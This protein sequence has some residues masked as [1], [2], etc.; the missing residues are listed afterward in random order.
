MQDAS[1]HR[2]QS[3]LDSY[4]R[5][6]KLSGVVAAVG[7]GTA[8]P[9]F[10]YAGRLSDDPGAS[11]VGPDSLWRI[12]SMTKPI[13]AMAAMLLVQDSKL[14]LDEPISDFIPA[15]KNV[16]VMI[17][18]ETSLDSRP[19]HHPIT[20]RELL[21]H[22]SGLGYQVIGTGPL[23]KEYA[24]LHLLGGRVAGPANDLQPNSL[25]AFAD[26]V[27][28]VPLRAEPGTAWNYSISLDILGRVIEVAS[29]VPF[30]RFVDERVLKPIGM[31][32]TYWTV[33]RDQADR[34]ATA[35]IW[36]GNQKVPIDTGSGSDWLHPP[37]AP[38]GGSG[39]VSSARDYDRFLQ[40]LAGHGSIGG[41]RVLKPETV[42]LAMSNLLPPG[43]HITSNITPAPVMAQGFG[44]GGEL[45]LN[46]VPNGVSAGT[47]GWF[48]AAGTIGFFDPRKNLRVTVMVNY[49]PGDKWPLYADVVK[50]LYSDGR[51]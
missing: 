32:S 24:R 48:G 41:V 3:V 13:T 7:R 26:K 38:Y 2:L 1:L 14:R 5:D 30:D 11:P 22:T 23:P 45:F 8:P 42:R 37:K 50:A 29:G 19:A 49:F 12:Y 6:H 39:L 21:T 43:V 34:L 10:V 18:P 4:V 16:R 17:S 33:P 36:Q 51:Q 47:F 9:R 20:V 40:M 28:T 31:T 25:E 15:F 44:A 46:D 27:A 35:Y